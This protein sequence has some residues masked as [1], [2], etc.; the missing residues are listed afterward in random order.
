[1]TAS[2]YSFSDK[3]ILYW[4]HYERIS[5]LSTVNHREVAHFSGHSADWWNLNGTYA[6]LHKMTAA[7]M[8]YIKSALGG[9]V[10][11]LSILDIGCGGGLVSEPLCR[12]GAK[13]TGIDADRSA[14]KIAKS[15]AGQQGLD[16]TYIASAAEDLVA[17]EQKFDAV[18][19]LEIL[20]HVDHPATFVKLCS[21]LVKPGGK[22]IFSTL[23]RTLKSYAL[24]IVV[25][26]RILGWAPEG[27]HDWNK[28]IK[29]SELAHMAEQAGL[30]VEDACGLV[31]RPLSGD[32]VLHPHDLDLNFFIVVSV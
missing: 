22:I 7:R 10:R 29:P 32:F 3:K 23:N 13:V 11:G 15:H 20:E 24:G 14:I 18:V 25:A 28:F 17:K 12:M 19:A 31:Y 1:M 8:G 16:I 27:T 26:E 21:Q 6:P 5:A 2:S 30:T 9:S 4:K